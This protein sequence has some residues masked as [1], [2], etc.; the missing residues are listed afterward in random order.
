[1]DH[2]A[3]VVRLDVDGIELDRLRELFEGGVVSAEGAER[4]ASGIMKVDEPTSSVV[5][6]E[7]AALAGNRVLAPGE[8]VTVAPAWTNTFGGALALTG[9]A[10]NLTGPGGGTYTILDNAAD[11]GNIGAGGTADCQV[12]TGNCYSM[13][14]SGARPAAH[15]DATFRETLSNGVVKTWTLHVGESFTDVPTSQLFYRAIESV[16]HAGITTGCTATTYCPGDQVTRSQMSLFLA[17]GVAA[18]SVAIPTSGVVGGQPYNCVAGGHSLFTDVT[19]T[20]IFCKSVHYL[21]SQNVTSGCSPTAYC[22]TPNVTRLEMS[23]FVARAVVAPLGGAGVPQTYGPDPVTGLS[24]SCNPG[25]PNIH[26][27][28][29][30]ASDTFCKHVHFLWAKG[31]ISGCGPTTYCPGDPVTRDAMARFLT[32]GFKV[33]LYGP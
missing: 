17:R 31:I 2:G 33:N 32:N 16:L 18:N 7:P 8:T 22:P 11:Y 28:D 10:S 15:W 3:V 24:Y 27:T 30:P 23:A 12:A 19:P 5:V 14:V 26:F 25:S 13:S 9:T 6:H 21:A 29:V 1:V 4:A 20:D